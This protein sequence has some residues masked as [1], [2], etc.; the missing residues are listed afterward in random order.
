MLLPILIGHFHDEGIGLFFAFSIKFVDPFEVFN[1]YATSKFL[2]MHLIC[3]PKF[4]VSITS[5]DFFGQLLKRS[6]ASV[7]YNRVVS[8]FQFAERFYVNAIDREQF[9][10]S[11]GVDQKS[12][13]LLKI[14]H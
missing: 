8:H 14:T 12:I 2:I 9:H 10:D 11:S 4:C 3:P 5:V 7:N 6:S 13:C 1:Q